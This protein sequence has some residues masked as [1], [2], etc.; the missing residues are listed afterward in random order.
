MYMKHNMFL[1]KAVGIGDFRHAVMENFAYVL[2]TYHM[3]INY[4]K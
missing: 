3:L 1:G 2:S 4:S